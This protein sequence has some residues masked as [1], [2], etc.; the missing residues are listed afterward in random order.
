LGILQIWEGVFG[1][2]QEEGSRVIMKRERVYLKILNKN[3]SILWVIK[4]AVAIGYLLHSKTWIQRG[5][6]NHASLLFPIDNIAK[7]GSN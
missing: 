4:H 2:K 3:I 1:C 6:L 7:Q 5:M